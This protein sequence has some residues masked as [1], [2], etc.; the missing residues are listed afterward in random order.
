MLSNESKNIQV[1]FA[2]TE[3]ALTS[4]IAQSH[5][6]ENGVASRKVWRFFLCGCVND[7]VFLPR[8]LSLCKVAT[9]YHASYHPDRRKYAGESVA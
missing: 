4:Q 5:S 1:V 9:M 7:S 2:A 8:Y 3:M 6:I